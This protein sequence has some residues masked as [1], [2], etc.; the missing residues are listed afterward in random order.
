MNKIKV[1]KR[2]Y[3]VLEAKPQKLPQI[4]NVIQS[5]AVTLES[6][7]IVTYNVKHTIF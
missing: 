3:Q 1:F 4:A 6:R 5:T 7:L 2:Q